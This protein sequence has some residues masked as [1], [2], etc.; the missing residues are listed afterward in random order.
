T[1][2][3]R[4]KAGF[5]LHRNDSLMTDG[6]TMRMRAEPLAEYLRKGL[7]PPPR[8]ER[9]LTDQEDEGKRIFASVRTGCAVC[10]VPASGFTDRSRQVLPGFRTLPLFDE[11]SGQGYKVP[12]LLYVGGTPPYYHDGTAATL[13]DV[14]EHNQDRMGKTAH[15]TPIER[16]ALVAYL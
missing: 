8:E 4:I 14:V 6:A 10:H 1:L 3:D 2:V 7:V 11:D 9:P 5:A 13:E 16:A 15:L 12:S